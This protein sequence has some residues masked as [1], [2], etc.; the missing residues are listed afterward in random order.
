MPKKELS[1]IVYVQNSLTLWDMVVCLKYILCAVMLCPS[2]G[3]MTFY[4]QS[5][6]KLSTAG[7]I[8]LP[9]NSVIYFKNLFKLQQVKDKSDKFPAI[10]SFTYSI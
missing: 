6:V 7:S 2:P 9:E 4:L 8:I 5:W 1:L 10:K 3:N